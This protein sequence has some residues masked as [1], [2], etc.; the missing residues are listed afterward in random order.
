MIDDAIVDSFIAWTRETG[1]TLYPAQEEATLA[2]AGGDHVILATPTGSGK[3]MVA[4]A[5]HFAALARGQ[6]SFYTAPIKALVSE[7]F[8]A[9]CEVFGAENVGMMTGDAT[10][11]GGA[12]IVCATAEIVANIALREGPD[13]HI[14]QVVMDEFHFYAEPDR[15][16]AWQVPLLLLNRAQ[17]L[18]MSATLGDVSQFRR[19]LKQRTGRDVELVTGTTRP[20]PLTSITHTPSTTPRRAAVRRQGADLRR[21]LQRGDRRAGATGLTAQRGGKGAHP[22]EIGDLLHDVL[23]PRAVEAGAEE[24]AYTTR[25]AAEVPGWSNARRRL[26]SHLCGTDQAGINV[27]IRTVPHRPGDDGTR[28]RILS[29]EFHQIAG[30]AGRAGYD[31]E[32]TV[33]QAP[34]TRSRT[35]AP[36]ADRTRRNEEAPFQGRP[37][38]RGDVAGEDVDKPS[39]S[40]QP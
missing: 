18:L 27:P 9:L 35:S 15:G 6:R 11:N 31:T 4:I 2:L 13:A 22:P 17:F 40:R 29:R 39:S 34:T 38:G 23:R 10:V 1:I 32:G 8:F 30:R 21:A 20:V 3:S 19:D 25:N 16:W 5:A 33:V 26:D 14:D 7:K 12:P 36:R 28:Q 37:Q 24:L